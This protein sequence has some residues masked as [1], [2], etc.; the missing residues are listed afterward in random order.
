[1]EGHGRPFRVILT[2]FAIVAKATDPLDDSKHD[3]LLQFLVGDDT[4]RLSLSVLA[5]PSGFAQP[6]KLLRLGA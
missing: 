6:K 1:M 2:Q 5:L 4:I 3:L